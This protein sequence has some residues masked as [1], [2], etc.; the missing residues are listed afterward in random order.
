MQYE[1]ITQNILSKEGRFKRYRD[2]VKQC[3]QNR[4][5]RYNNRK[6]YPTIWWRMLEDKQQPDAKEQNNFRVEYGCRKIITE[7]P[8]GYVTWIQ[9]GT[10]SVI[11]ILKKVPN[12]KTL[13]HDDVHC[14]WFWKFTSICDRL[15]FELSW[16]LEVDIPKWMTDGN[17]TLIQKDLTKGTIHN[18]S[19]PITCLPMM[20]KILIEQNRELIYYSLVSHIRTVTG[21][22]ER[23]PLGN[24]R[25]KW[26]TLLWSMSS[27]GEQIRLRIC[28]YVVKWQKKK[29]YDIVLWTW[30]INFITEAM[31]NSKVALTARKN[32]AKVK[33]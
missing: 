29:V 27:A 13:G 15:V 2:R 31:K 10:E 1:V 20:W 11:P 26:F 5:F 24:Q 19:R 32:L 16:Y 30:I 4:T 7:R 21:K 8:N 33:I 28:R 23:M 22:T 12:W 14:F 3:K 25:N 17:S 18:N 9:K 6:F